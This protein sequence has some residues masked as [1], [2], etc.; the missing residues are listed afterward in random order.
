MTAPYYQD[1]LVT[2]YHGDARDLAMQIPQRIDVV[3][4]DPPY[5]TGG[6]RRGEAGQGSD[7][8]GG[9]VREVWDE[10]AVDWLTE[11]WPVITFWPSSRAWQLLARANDCGLTKHRGLYWQKPDPRPQ[12]GGR[13]SWS[14]EPVWVLSQDGFLLY[15]DTDLYRE[16]AIRMNRN[17]EAVGHPY[18]KPLGVMRWLVG[19]TRTGTIL[20]PFSGSGSTLVAA[21]SLGRLAV[22]IEQDERWC[23]IAAQRCSQEVLG[24][25][26][27][28]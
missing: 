1:D 18:Q 26:I 15:G 17:E 10:G 20:D 28:A 9:L 7:P 12:V 21:K 14:I 22:G 16:S 2:I 27:P 13:I 25:E 23:E 5:G 24:L 19:K 3:V 11:Q 4:T 6:W 8:S